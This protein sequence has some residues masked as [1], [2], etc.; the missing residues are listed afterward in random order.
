MYI[1]GK[2]FKKADREQ[3]VPLWVRTA[4]TNLTFRSWNN[5]VLYKRA[6]STCWCLKS[7]I[8]ATYFTLCSPSLP[9]GSMCCGALWWS[10]PPWPRLSR[11]RWVISS[12]GV[13]FTDKRVTKRGEGWQLK[14]GFTFFKTSMTGPLKDLSANIT[15]A[16]KRSLSFFLRL[17]LGV[18]PQWGDSGDCK[19]GREIDMQQ[20]SP[21]GD[22]CKIQSLHSLQ[23]CMPKFRQS[24]A[25]PV[26][27]S[28]IK[29]VPSS[30][31]SIKLPLC[32]SIPPLQISK[33][34]TSRKALR[35]IFVLKR[36]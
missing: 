16:A 28:Q 8:S 5:Y 29:W 35:G 17:F 25:S 10:R 33:E 1:W 36:L 6:Y 13:R 34:K 27:V 20:R 32:V 26:A 9:A 30:F 21:A 18:F 4:Y 7:C 22:R 23:K 3:W 31:L 15:L 12:L 24:K 19:Q 14:D 11:G 2:R